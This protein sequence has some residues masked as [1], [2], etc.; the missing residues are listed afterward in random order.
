VVHTAPGI[1]DSRVGVR[2]AQD[3]AVGGERDAEPRPRGRVHDN[4]DH[5][6]DDLH[7]HAQLDN[8]HHDVERYEDGD[9]DGDPS[10]LDLPPVSLPLPRWVLELH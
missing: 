7:D 2:R 1:D 4:D 6:H 8:E 3:N 10:L 9:D 5:D